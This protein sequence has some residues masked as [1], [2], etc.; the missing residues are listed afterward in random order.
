MIDDINDDDDDESQIIENPSKIKWYLIDTE[1]NPCIVWNFFITL[2]IIY[3]LVVFPYV[4]VFKE[5]Y[6]NTVNDDGVVSYVFDTATQKTLYKIE[7]AIDIIQTIE[8]FLNFIK[9]SISSSYLQGYF[10]FDFI[11]TIPCLLFYN[12]QWPYYWLKVFR[13]I[14]IFRLTIPLKYFMHWALSK[15]SKKR[16]ND[17]SGFTSLILFVVYISHLMACIWLFLG[18]M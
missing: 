4:V 6:I 7:L 10:V 11:G 9:Y 16:Q 5:V 13:F 3:N 18:K 2:L 8:I 15:Y 12:E 17:L 14:H 1:K